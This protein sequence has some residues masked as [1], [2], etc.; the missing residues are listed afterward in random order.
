[1]FG[2]GYWKRDGG[3]LL[4]RHKLAGSSVQLVSPRDGHALT[5]G[6]NGYS[7]NANHFSI[8]FIR[9]LDGVL[10]HLFDRDTGGAGITLVRCFRPVQFRSVG[11][12][13]RSGHGQLVTVDL[14]R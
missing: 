3:L 1:M 13:S 7:G 12:A 4:L 8:A 6:S 11:L 10:A 9:L 2:Q 14:V 5:V